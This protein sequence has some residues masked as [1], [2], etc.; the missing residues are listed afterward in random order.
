V[1]ENQEIFDRIAPSWYN[2]RHRTIF[3]A[4][5]EELARR[6]Q[7]GRLLNVGCGHGPDFLPF[8]GNFELHGLDISAG[9][10]EMAEKYAAKFDFEV[11]L[12][13]A[14]ATTLPYPNGY[15]EWAIAV[16]SYHH[17]LD[18]D[19]QQRA[20]RELRRI[21]KPGG[22]AFITVW[23]RRQRRFWFRGKVVRVPWRSRDETL[24]RRYYLFTYRELEKLAESTGFK[25]ISTGPESKYHGWWPTFSR[26][27]CLL[28]KKTD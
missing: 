23:N 26:N 17:L 3:Q 11:N 7:H 13:Q 10:L 12:T 20:F 21:L 25:I 15:F 9:M 27:I 1:T 16:A 4:E 14:D 24:F 6:W 22:E 19:S 2:F 18:K 28:V 8:A 5:L